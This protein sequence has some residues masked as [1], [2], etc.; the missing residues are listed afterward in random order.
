MDIKEIGESVQINIVSFLS[1]KPLWV[2]WIVYSLL[3]WIFLGILYTA[4]YLMAK[5]FMILQWWVP[6][7][8][9]MLCGLIW[10]SFAHAGNLRKLNKADKHE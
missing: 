9:V 7:I 8:I 3:S 2:Y 6:V 5:Y 1:S 4:L 10:G